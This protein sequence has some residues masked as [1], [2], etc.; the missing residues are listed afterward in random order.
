MKTFASESYTIA[1]FKIADFVARGEKERA[2]HMYPLLM[3]S[4]AEPAIAYQLEGDILLAFDDMAS[5]TCYNK[6]VDLYK[7]SGKFRQAIGVYEHVHGFVQDEKI[8]KELLD[9][10]VL[11]D[12]VAGFCTTFLKLAKFY[13]D[14]GY[15]PILFDFVQSCQMVMPIKFFTLLHAY[16]IRCVIRYGLS[17]DGLSEKIEYCLELFLASSA[18]DSNL[19]KEFQRFL[20]EIK[21]VDG[22][23][24]E[25]I[26]KFLS[27]K[28]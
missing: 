3:H 6:A 18:Q 26:E 9:L 16:Y 2:L 28:P 11:C 21:I 22:I 27:K 20:L 12:D 13:V 4:I 7:K 17:N 24:F 10:Y 8:L 19:D 23:E 15:F 5:L 14:H 25:K 1:W